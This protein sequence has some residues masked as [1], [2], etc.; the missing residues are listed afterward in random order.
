MKKT[1]QLLQGPLKH[2]R[3]AALAAALLPLASVMATPASAQT[4]TSCSGGICG[5]VFDDVNNNGILDAGETGIEFVKVFVCQLCDTTDTIA[6]ETGPGGVYSIFLDPTTT[7]VSVLMPTGT[8]AS[9]PNK[10]DD[11]FDSDGIPDGT[12]YSVA[13]WEPGGPPNDFGVFTPLTQ[14]PGTGTPGYWKNHPEAWPLPASRSAAS[15]TRKRRRSPGSAR[16]A[17]TR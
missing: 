8:Q 4:T 10:G 13:L 16:S 7:T 1:Q 11:H 2:I 14:Q 15:T 6:I 5:V 12:G 3:A 17:R 9:P